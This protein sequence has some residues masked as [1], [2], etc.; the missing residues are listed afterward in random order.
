MPIKNTNW[1]NT[2]CNK[3]SLKQIQHANDGLDFHASER[4][5][6]DP[7]ETEF[8]KAAK[9]QVTCYPGTGGRGL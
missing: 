4:R 8:A 7:S 1:K 6:G 9:A 2:V 5:K 3:Y